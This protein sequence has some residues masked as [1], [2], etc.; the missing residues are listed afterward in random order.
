MCNIMSCHHVPYMCDM[1][2][3]LF[4]KNCRE[5]VDKYVEYDGMIILLDVILH[6]RQAYRHILYNINFQV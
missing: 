4:Q 5:V 6:K 1:C 2:L 3:L